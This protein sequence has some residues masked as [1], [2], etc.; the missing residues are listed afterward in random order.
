MNK[1]DE[2]I[3]RLHHAIEA[4]QRKLAELKSR[5][6]VTAD[7]V[8]F[9]AAAAAFLPNGEPVDIRAPEAKSCA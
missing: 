8:V 2:E 9:G 4:E 7:A 5:P 3:A 1:H 6:P